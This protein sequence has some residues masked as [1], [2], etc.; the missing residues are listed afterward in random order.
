M[1]WVTRERPKIDRIACPWLITQ[2]I[3]ENPEFLYVPSDQVR[4]V[5]ETTGAIPY[6]IPGVELSH[7]EEL[8]S[9]DAFLKKY[10]LTEPALDRLAKIVRGADTSRHDLAPAKRRSTST[11]ICFSWRLL[12]SSGLRD[13]QASTA[14]CLTAQKC[15]RSLSS[16]NSSSLSVRPRGWR[17]TASRSARAWPIERRAKRR[18]KDE[19][20]VLRGHLEHDPEKWGPV[21]RKDHAR[22]NT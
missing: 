15:V 17:S 12:S 1:K 6:D 13:T 14:P 18:L 3:D 7:V 16:S 22:T 2:F 8:C 21:F 10:D 9:F 11:A 19:N 4:V 5:A 20:G